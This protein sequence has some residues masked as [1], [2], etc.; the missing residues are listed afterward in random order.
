MV[1]TPAKPGRRGCQRCGL[2]LH[3]DAIRAGVTICG[4]CLE[5]QTLGLEVGGGATYR[6]GAL[7]ALRGAA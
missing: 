3:T 4:L 1:S 6:P 5:E 2:G 7:E